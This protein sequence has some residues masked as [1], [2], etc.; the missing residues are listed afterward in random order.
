M[1]ET[2]REP[3][4]R[5][6]LIAV[7]SAALIVTLSMGVRQGFG[8]LL[9]PLGREL[10]VSREAF[11]LAI[12]VQ[13]L[14]FGLAQPFV[15]ALADKHGARRLLAGGAA[16][17]AAGLALAASAQSSLGVLVGMGMLVG[18]ALS[19][20][21]FVVALG[22]VGRLVSPAQRSLAFGLVTAGGSLGQF[23]IVPFAQQLIASFGWRAALVVLAGA[24]ATIALAGLGF[25][26]AQPDARTSEPAIPLRHVIA[27]ALRHRHYVLLNLGFFVCGF[28]IAFVGTHL[29]AYLVD[30][31]LGA[32]VGAQ[33][34]ALIGLFNIAG[35]YLFGAW[36]AKRSKP[37]LL[38]ALYFGRAAA[39]AVFLMLPTTPA[40]VALFAATF[41]FLWL[42]TV[43]LTSGA[44]A[45][46]FGLRYLSMLYGLVFLSHQIGSFFGAWWAGWLFD[47]TGNYDL[48]WAASLLLGVAGG[49]IS[50]MTRDAPAPRLAVAT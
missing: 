5:V 38:G 31:G 32:G 40:S 46:M 44:V 50:L 35:S 39:I 34:L 24:I 10:G 21:T 42:G 45:G 17:Y 28:H 36:G 20:T 16:V 23:A 48:V 43:P 13:N 15:G 37:R 18:L 2:R 49:V 4:T 19:A 3:W 6:A 26:K 9:Q 33:A 7:A 30:R 41:G 29:P 14:L 12:A 8:L 1:N 25:P 27:Q 11:G 22:A 47:R